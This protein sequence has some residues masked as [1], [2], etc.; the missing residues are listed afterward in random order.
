[1]AAE[2][3][4][5]FAVTD[6]PTLAWSAVEHGRGEELAK[7]LGRYERWPWA[8][9]ARAYCEWRP[10]EAAEICATIGALPIEAYTR[11]RAAEQLVAGGRGAEANDQV[12]RAL[13]FYR[14]VGATAFVR[15]A[16]TLLPASA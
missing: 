12:R 6:L 14:S 9:A 7:L 1:L 13:A 4:I 16:E 11:L 2:E 15:R 3:D 8:R 10:L 5:G